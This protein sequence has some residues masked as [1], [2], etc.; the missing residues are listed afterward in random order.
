MVWNNAFRTANR[1]KKINSMGHLAC[2]ESW[3]R[4]CI[5]TTGSWAGHAHCS[6]HKLTRAHSLITTL[7]HSNLR[8][9]LW[10]SKRLLVGL[11]RVEVGLLDYWNLRAM[12][13]N[14]TTLSG[15]SPTL[16]IHWSLPTRYWY[17]PQIVVPLP[18]ILRYSGIELTF[19]SG[20]L[21]SW[22][23]GFYPRLVN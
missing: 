21:L 13:S 19:D 3:A 12:A 8:Y 10:I 18:S 11:K 14:I 16:F 22:L 17:L 20:R 1:Q 4:R 15:I 9:Y 7:P 5:R 6:S 23:L 2:C